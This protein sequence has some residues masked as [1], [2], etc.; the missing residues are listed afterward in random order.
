MKRAAEFDTQQASVLE[1]FKLRRMVEGMSDT[2]GDALVQLE[3][4]DNDTEL[5]RYL[6]DEQPSTSMTDSVTRL[7]ESQVVDLVDETPPPST[8]V[9]PTKTT[10]PEVLGFYEG[11][12]VVSFYE[13]LRLIDEA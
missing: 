8:T 7:T 5:Q 6:V 12:R 9:S 11:L 3:N 2:I 13:H 1:L 10:E 4:L